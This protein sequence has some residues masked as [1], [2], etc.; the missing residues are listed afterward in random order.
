MKRKKPYSE[1]QMLCV[2]SHMWNLGLKKNKR[3]RTLG[4]QSAGLGREKEMMR[5]RV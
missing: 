4:E 1:I 2:F 5:S 3:K